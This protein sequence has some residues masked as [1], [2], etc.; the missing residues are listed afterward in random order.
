M[1]FSVDSIWVL[2]G[3]G[4][5]AGIGLGFGG[6]LGLCGGVAW[7]KASVWV[8]VKIADF[9]LYNARLIKRRWGNRHD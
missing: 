5:V 7:R 2:C 4:V 1:T 9:I 8:G 6:Y 3:L